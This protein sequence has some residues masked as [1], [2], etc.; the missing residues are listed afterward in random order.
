MECHKCP[1]GDAIAAG[2]YRRTPWDKVPCSKCHPKSGSHHGRSHVAIFSSANPGEA[3]LD[4]DRVFDFNGDPAV[5]HDPAADPVVEGM[6]FLAK[7]IL[8]LSPRTREIVLDRLAYPDRPLRIVAERIGISTSS[9]H[10]RLKKARR[11]W[12]ALAYAIAMKSWSW[13]SQE[14]EK[15]AYGRKRTMPTKQRA[16]VGRRRGM[17][18]ATV[19]ESAS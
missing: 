19:K 3:E 5:V 14:A 12:P 10:N 8:A 1:V 15:P 11:N 2:I 6:A 17:N 13:S 18:H 16:A 9:A 4:V 7:Q